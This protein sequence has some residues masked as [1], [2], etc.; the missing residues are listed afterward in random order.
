MGWDPKDK[1]KYQARE[2]A[3]LAETAEVKR[4]GF[5]EEAALEK[6]AGR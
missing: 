6:L 3:D 1:A 2:K 5:L 4:A